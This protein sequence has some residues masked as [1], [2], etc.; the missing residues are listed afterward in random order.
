MER[1]EISNIE[2]GIQSAQEI[3]QNSVAK[4]VVTKIA[5]EGSVHDERMGPMDNGVKCVTCGYDCKDCAGHFGHIELNI[6]IMHPMYHRNVVS[7]LKCFCFN[8]HR[9]ILSED[10]LFLSEISKFSKETK[11]LKII[12]KV[13]KMDCCHHCEQPKAKIMYSI[14]D[15]MIYISHNKSKIVISDERIKSIF[16]NVPNED[17]NMIGIDPTMN[18]PKNLIITLLPVIPPRSRPYVISDGTTCDDD[19]TIQYLEIIKANNH[20][21]DEDLNET[22]RQKF[23]Q[24][25]KFRIRTLMN[26]SQGKARHSNGKAIKAI[27]ERI[28]GKEGRIRCNLL[29]KR[30]NQSARTVIT[31]DPTVRTCEVVVPRLI[32]ENLS[33]PERV[34]TFNKHILQAIIDQNKA[35]YVLKNGNRINLKYAMNK[36]KGVFRGD[37]IVRDG[38]QMTTNTPLLKGDKII[39]NGVEITP[40]P[41]AFHLDIGDVV[42]RHLRDGDMVMFNRQPSLHKNNILAKKVVVRDGK[43]FRFNLASTRQYNAD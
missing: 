6:P 40:Q 34:T 41:F 2:F 9:F 1:L 24:H 13:E 39:R 33:I 43:T 30:T 23:L 21:L 36:H 38:K 37:V 3:L 17:V 26:N 7:F 14:S 31:P 16:D 8:C 18:H 12:E 15:K 22:K 19:L 35:N 27:K 42:E 11:F 4:I 32:A 20:L 5:G 10:H 29:G 25:L 28:T